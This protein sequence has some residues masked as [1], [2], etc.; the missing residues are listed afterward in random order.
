MN[1]RELDRAKAESY[2]RVVE[3]ARDAVLKEKNKL[4]AKISELEQSMNTLISMGANFKSHSVKK[5]EDTLSRYKNL[6]KKA[7]NDL[8]YLNNILN[9]LNNNVFNSIDPVE[10]KIKLRDLRKELSDIN[11]VVD[12]VTRDLRRQNLEDKKNRIKI[13]FDKRIRLETDPTKRSILSEYRNNEIKKLDN[14]INNLNKYSSCTDVQRQDYIDKVNDKINEIVNS[15][16]KTYEEQLQDSILI[17]K[18]LFTKYKNNYAGS[19]EEVKQ[20]NGESTFSYIM[21]STETYA[22]LGNQIDQLESKLAAINAENKAKGKDL[23]DTKQQLKGEVSRNQMLPYRIRDMQKKKAAINSEQRLIMLKRQQVIDKKNYQISRLE[24][25]SEQLKRRS[26]FKARIWVTDLK[27]KA[28]KRKPIFLKTPRS[29]ILSE[30][31]KDSFL[32]KA[33]FQQNVYNENGELIHKRG[34]MDYRTWQERAVE[35]MEE[36]NKERGKSL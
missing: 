35:R 6:L 31:I 8:N 20:Y 36:E 3:I 23:Y 25:K 1:E 26:A 24:S 27:I 32:R 15:P 21:K 5:A 12:N 11:Y 22:K 7:N 16:I 30:K 10:R 4:E 33:A 2:K 19:N 29:I 18:P 17:V 13:I 9:N 34:D 14:R 28:L